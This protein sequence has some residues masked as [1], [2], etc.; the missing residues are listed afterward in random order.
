MQREKN[1]EKQNLPGKKKE[2]NIKGD[3]S[4]INSKGLIN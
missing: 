2:L 4:S 1:T 3:Q